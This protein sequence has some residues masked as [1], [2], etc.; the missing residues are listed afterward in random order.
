MQRLTEFIVHSHLHKLRQLAFTLLMFGELHLLRIVQI[1]NS[2]LSRIRLFFQKLQ[3]ALH[4]FVHQ[5]EGNH[6][7]K[8]DS[9]DDENDDNDH[10]NHSQH[11][12][13]ILATVL[14]AAAT[15]QS[16]ATAG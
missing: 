4:D 15:S 10:H 5:Q 3:V 14:R 8:E 1:D 12:Q 11:H 9:N 2:E 6:R 7:T 13:T 16:S